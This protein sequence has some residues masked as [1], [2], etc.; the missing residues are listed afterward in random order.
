MTA[1]RVLALV[2][3]VLSLLLLTR[4]GP[5]AWRTWRIFAGAKTRRM[6]DAG[7]LE[8][9]PPVPVGDRLDE[10]EALGFRRIGERYLQLPGSPL[11]YEWLV[12]DESGETY[13]VAVPSVV[14]GTLVAAY[15]SF[16][17][18]TWV[19]TNFPRGETIVRRS[20]FA[21]F[22]PTN[23]TD[24]IAAHRRQVDTLR[25]AHGNPRLIHTMADTLRM[26]ADYR[27]RHGGAT[28][29]RLTL[30]I[31][32]PAL[33]ALGLAVICGLLLLLDR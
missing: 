29:R 25:A 11:R 15:S 19:Q 8:I 13:V 21:S 4:F 2:G 3:L 27:T 31:M 6:A 7:P 26:D 17:D 14:V 10:L 16:D 33:A 18:G 30:R 23:L 12:G 22:V 1:D 5:P 9:P 24:M 32:T 20:F 28:L